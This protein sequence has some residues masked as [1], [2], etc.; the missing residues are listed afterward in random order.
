MPVAVAARQLDARADAWYGTATAAALVREEQRQIAPLLTRCR[1]VR[2][3]FLRPHAALPA[4]LSGHLLQQIVALARVRGG[5][6]GE[7][8]MPGDALALQR[9][10]VDL[11]VALHTL[12]DAPRRADLLLEYERVLSSEGILLVVELN[13][14][15]PFRWRWLRRGPRAFGS[16]ACVHA[17][18][19]AGFDVVSRYAV[20]PLL[21]WL[22]P[23][24]AAPLGR[25]FPNTVLRAGYVLLAR[26]RIASPVAARPRARVSLQPG[27]LSG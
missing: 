26:K 13:P 3:L 27:M 8:R 11:I 9:D 18:R 24:R 12:A 15:S 19:E 23:D 17:L 14:W 1:G 7:A 10:A 4:A 6:D 22:R 21:P 5:W 20:G 2:G 25:Y 16:G